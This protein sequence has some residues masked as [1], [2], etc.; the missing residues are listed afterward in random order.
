M[1]A[2]VTAFALVAMT[3]PAVAAP[4]PALAMQSLA[5]QTS[6]L[7]LASAD[8]QKMLALRIHRAARTMCAGEVIEN[9]PQ[10]IRATRRCIA[11]ATSSAFAAAR[12]KRAARASLAGRD[13]VARA[14]PNE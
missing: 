2:I 3:L 5:V 7:N 9:L 11:D 8:G 14:T 1:K 10:S 13:Q 12:T 4:A 6:D